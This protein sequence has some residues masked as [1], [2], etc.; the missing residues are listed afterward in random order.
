M[1]ASDNQPPSYRLACSSCNGTG[2]IKSVNNKVEL[3]CKCQ[4]CDGSGEFDRYTLRARVDQMA[5]FMAQVSPVLFAH[6]IRE[7][8]ACSVELAAP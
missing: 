7:L 6:V 3:S 4:F 2:Q 5:L 8:E 1:T